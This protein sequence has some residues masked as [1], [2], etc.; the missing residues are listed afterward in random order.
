MKKT[1]KKEAEEKIKEFFKNLKSKT[2]KNNKE[3]TPREVKKIKRLAMSHKI[4][5][6]NLRKKFCKK[7]YSI[8][9]LKNSQTRIKNKKKIIKCLNCNY[10]SRWEIR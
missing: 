1:T 9:S 6:G 5:L 2:S 8:F 7:C 3:K 4:K 10:V